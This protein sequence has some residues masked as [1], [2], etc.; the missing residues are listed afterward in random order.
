MLEIKYIIQMK[1]YYLLLVY[2]EA[3]EYL[4]KVPFNELGIMACNQTF[5]NILFTSLQNTQYGIILQS[6]EQQQLPD[7]EEIYTEKLYRVVHN[8]VQGIPDD[9]AERWKT[10]FLEK[11]ELKFYKQVDGEQEI[12][13]FEIRPKNVDQV[14]QIQNLQVKAYQNPLDITNLY[15][16]QF[17]AIYNDNYQT[18]FC[19][20]FIYN[21]KNLS[22]KQDEV[23]QYNII[24]NNQLL[25]R[26]Q[27]VDI[28][29]EIILTSQI[30]LS[31]EY[32]MVQILTTYFA[33]EIVI[34]A[35]VQI[36]ETSIFLDYSGCKNI[37]Y[38]GQYFYKDDFM[39]VPCKGYSFEDLNLNKEQ[40]LEESQNVKLYLQQKHDPY[41]SNIQTMIQG[42]SLDKNQLI[43]QF[44]YYNNYEV[45]RFGILLIDK[46]EQAV[47][48]LIVQ[49]YLVNR[50]MYIVRKENCPQKKIQAQ[51]SASN[52]YALDITYTIK[53]DAQLERELK[54]KMDS[55]KAQ[56]QSYYNQRF[57][58]NNSSEFLKQDN[59]SKYIKLDDI[60]EQE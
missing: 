18:L 2:G 49:D 9:A 47:S 38:S 48:K 43:S 21:T 31:S 5:T 20:L 4:V 45:E 42:I 35:K 41:N 10:S 59:A 13:T 40:Q 58:I 53:I 54:Q 44:F 17:I 23:Q 15:N 46:S 12:E 28:D 37:E 8:E 56:R 14:Q 30:S 57:D 55:R 3:I 1:S 39:A 50:Q 60:S 11:Q 25:Y 51:L 19:Q 26:N 36:I 34:D 22:V 6:Q 24:K 33:F 32:F 29:K 52:H 27:D 16:I 7:G